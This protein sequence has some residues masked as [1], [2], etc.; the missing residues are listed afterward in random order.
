[1][2]FSLQIFNIKNQK[3]ALLIS[4]RKGILSKVNKAI[5]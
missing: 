4:R 3:V 5:K 2:L 1:M